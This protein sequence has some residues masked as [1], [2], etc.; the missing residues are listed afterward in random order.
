VQRLIGRDAIERAAHGGAFLA[1]VVAGAVLVHVVQV[2]A[3]RTP[4]GTVFRTESPEFHD[5]LMSMVLGDQTGLVTAIERPSDWA[6]SD[7]AGQTA[8]DGGSSLL[9][10]WEHGG[11]DAAAILTFDRSASGYRL[12]IRAD[13]GFRIGCSELCIVEELRIRLSE[14]VPPGAI[15]VRRDRSPCA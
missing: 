6:N 9:V 3:A 12:D 1:L 11:C 5:Q 4:P 14:P 8:A 15:S 2:V 10:A 7:P 13:H